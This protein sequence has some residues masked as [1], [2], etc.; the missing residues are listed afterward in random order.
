VVSVIGGSSA[1]GGLDSRRILRKHHDAPA[2]HQPQQ[3]ALVDPSEW[4]IPVST[5][6][7]ERSPVERDS[8]GTEGA[9]NEAPYIVHEATPAR[10]RYVTERSV[11]IKPGETFAP[12]TGNAAVMFDD[13]GA[14]FFRLAPNQQ[15]AFGWNGLGRG[16]DT[17]DTL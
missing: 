12:G 14:F 2:V 11:G 6:Q 1:I 9:V 13:G 3:A 8:D 10:G 7:V 15:S 5:E 4:P 16:R 17:L